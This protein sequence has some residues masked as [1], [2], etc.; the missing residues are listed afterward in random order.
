MISLTVILI[1]CHAAVYS[2][3]YRWSLSTATTTTTRVATRASADCVEPDSFGFTDD[4]GKEHLAAGAAWSA[5]DSSE[6][7]SLLAVLRAKFH[8][9]ILDWGLPLLK[10]SALALNQLHFVVLIVLYRGL[11]E[12][13]PVWDKQRKAA[14]RDHGIKDNEY[15]YL[16]LL[17]TN[18]DDEGRGEHPFMSA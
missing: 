2:G 11:G 3:N 10:V 6:K 14:A 9:S 16:E 13:L 1:Y 5:P 15:W 4:D 17:F 18:P 12:Y 8:R 7:A